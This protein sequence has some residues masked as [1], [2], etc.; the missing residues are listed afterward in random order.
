MG[1]MI[2]LFLADCPQRLA[3]IKDAIRRGDAEALGRAAHTLKGSIGNFAAKKA[4]VAAQRL[5][6]MGRAGKLDK[7]SEASMHLESELAAL[8]KELRKLTM[9]PSMRKEKTDKDGEKKRRHR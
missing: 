2:R 1:E 4:F 3:E 6:I 7:A 5:E 9:K 8:N